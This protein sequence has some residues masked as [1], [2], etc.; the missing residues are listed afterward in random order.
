MNT[1][2]ILCTT[3][4]SP[5]ATLAVKY[6][7]RLSQQLGASLHILNVFHVRRATGSFKSMDD[8]I[9]QDQE[10]EMS[11]LKESFNTQG[12]SITTK[13]V[14]GDII[15]TINRYVKHANIDLIV[16][17]TQGSNSLKTTILGSTTKATVESST[18]PV[19]AIPYTHIDSPQLTKMLLSMDNK[20]LKS[21]DILNVPLQLASIAYTKI[22]I[23]HIEKDNAPFLLDVSG[24]LGQAAGEVHVRKGDDVIQ[25]IKS[26]SEENNIDLL[27]MIKRKK[28]FL[29]KLL[30]K[31]NTSSELGITRTP[32]LILSE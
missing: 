9:R 23:L 2:N 26:F 12:I 30:T 31:G 32:L 27:I 29:Q 21:A 28:S 24:Y 18:V 7:H 8:L 14:K 16:M 11:K 3:D 25:E 19:L 17:G 20:E 6:A 15:N 5:H 22:N 4:F 1:L 10:D 13:V